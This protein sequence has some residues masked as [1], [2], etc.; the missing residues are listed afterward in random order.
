MPARYRA[1]FSRWRN[2]TAADRYGNTALWIAGI[3][4]GAD[5]GG[6]GEST[7]PLFA[8]DAAHLGGMDADELSRVRSQYASVELSD[9]ASVT[10][11]SALGAIRANARSL[12][13]QTANL[14]SDSFSSDPRLNSEVSV[15]NKIN[16]ASVL[17]LRSLQ[18]SNKL[19]GSLLEQQVIAAKQQ[20]EAAANAINADILRRRNLLRN[21]GQ[22]TDGLTRSLETFR[23]P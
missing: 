11:M 8:Y 3:N 4:T 20:R 22:V 12:E 23:M 17:T 21:L 18:D 7:V 1:A 16:A 9:G 2:A 5:N 10:A 15:L 14:E 19:L 6:Y 13:A